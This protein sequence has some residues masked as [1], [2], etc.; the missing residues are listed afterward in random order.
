M[1][2]EWDS[3]TYGEKCAFVGEHGKEVVDL[4]SVPPGARVL[5]LGCGRGELTAY[6]VQRG[7]DAEGMDASKAQLADAKRRFPEIVFF[8]GDITSRRLF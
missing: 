1:N 8:E 4:L 2:I 7:W 5:D 3:K 6:L